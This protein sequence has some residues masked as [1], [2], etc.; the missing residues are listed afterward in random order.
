MNCTAELG[1][2]FATTM[3][4]K[5]FKKKSGKEVMERTP[6]QYATKVYWK[7]CEGI[8]IWGRWVVEIRRLSDNKLITLEF[9][10]EHFAV[11]Y[12]SGKYIPG[13]PSIKTLFKEKEEVESREKRKSTVREF[14]V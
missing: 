11:D 7:E 3:T 14:L 10:K 4:E 1:A 13:K 9:N 8:G 12:A 6:I 5:M 2:L